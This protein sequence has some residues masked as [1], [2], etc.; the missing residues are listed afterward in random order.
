MRP[1]PQGESWWPGHVL[2]YTGAGFNSLL[3]IKHLA[4]EKMAHGEATPAQLGTDTLQTHSPTRVV[5][6]SVPVTTTPNP[7]THF[8][9]ETSMQGEDSQ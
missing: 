5:I 7:E 2:G 6:F 1:R 3:W 9:R 4:K 8:Q